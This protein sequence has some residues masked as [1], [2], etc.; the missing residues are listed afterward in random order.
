MAVGC[1]PNCIK[2]TPLWSL[3]DV[4]DTNPEFCLFESVVGE[5]NDIAG[6]PVLYYRAKS[7][8]DRLYGEDANQDFYEPVETRLVYEPTEEPNIIDGLGIRSDETLQYSLIPK[9]TFTRDIGS[10]I[11]GVPESILCVDLGTTYSTNFSV[12]TTG[13]T[14]TGL[15]VDTVASGGVITK[16]TINEY[17]KGSDY[18][19]GDTLTITGG[20][21]NATFDIITTTTTD[22]QPLPGDVIKTLW[23]NRNYEIVD[24]GAEQSI[25]MARKLIWEFILRP[26]RFSE[27]SLKAEEIHRSTPIW[28]Q[29]YIYPDGETADI[30]YPDGTEI[31]GVP[32]D[33]LDIDL[34][35]LECGYKYKRD[36]DGGF[37]VMEMELEFEADY[38]PHPT[39]EE[40]G[41]PLE[42][43]SEE[44]YGDNSWIEVESDKIDDYG[45]VDTIMFSSTQAYPVAYGE[46][47]DVTIDQTDV[48]AFADFLATDGEVYNINITLTA[49]YVYIVIPV[50]LNTYL[51]SVNGLSVGFEE[52]ADTLYIS[53]TQYNCTVYKSQYKING[54]TTIVMTPEGC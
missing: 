46:S 37:T 54:A 38:S 36:A 34:S 11:L 47:T 14:G 16:V 2:G 13:G 52:T 1:P 42:N 19:V 9:S 4:T 15:Y 29:I 21:N 40:T 17:N 51:F 41:K 50:Q 31:I 6:F 44:A 7:K 39:Y 20:D 32:V 49:S 18:T 3:Y 43:K 8:M 35:A 25:F 5:Y 48:D 10:A 33:T 30:L 27:Q 26:F 28:V 24:I 53:G 12:P 22:I 45:D 23:N